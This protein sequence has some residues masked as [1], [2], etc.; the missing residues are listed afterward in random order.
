MVRDLAEDWKGSKPEILQG[1]SGSGNRVTAKTRRARELKR[2][3]LPTF[4][5]LILIA[6]LRNDRE[7]RRKRYAVSQLFVN[8]RSIKGRSTAF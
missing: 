6:V 8:F 1:Q 2:W 5:L 7:L 3:P 4:T